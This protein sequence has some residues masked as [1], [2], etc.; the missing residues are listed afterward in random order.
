MDSFTRMSMAA[1][2]PEHC[3]LE[4][5]GSVAANFARSEEDEDFRH[6]LGGSAEASMI[7]EMR[8]DAA[9]ARY[10][11]EVQQHAEADA[12]AL[13]K[14][15]ARRKARLAALKRVYARFKALF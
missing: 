11:D 14:Q 12:R 2:I 5:V 15:Q 7:R 1:I 6:S 8:G 10:L 9:H 3:G 4:S 13:A